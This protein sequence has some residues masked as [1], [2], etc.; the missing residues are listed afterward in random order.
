M[1]SSRRYRLHLEHST[2][3]GDIGSP[4]NPGP[5]I[6]DDYIPTITK[7][8]FQPQPAVV[9]PSQMTSTESK[10]SKPA[11][12]S[13]AT[14]PSREPT[15][16]SQNCGNLLKQA[17]PAMAGLLSHVS[18]AN[19]VSKDEEQHSTRQQPRVIEGIFFIRSPERE[20]AAAKKIDEDDE[21]GKDFGLGKEDQ[22]T[23]KSLRKDLNQLQMYP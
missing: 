8:K 19:S 21:L 2:S 18:A 3:V 20:L 11:K 6:D 5:S 16:P 12:R 15:E 13:N 4:C 9:K 22:K 17:A 23:M 14:R 7:K 10:D 1:H